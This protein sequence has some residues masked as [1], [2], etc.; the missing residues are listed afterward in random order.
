MELDKQA[1]ERFQKEE[2][3]KGVDEKESI[4]AIAGVT[5]DGD[6]TEDLFSEC[7]PTPNKTLCVQLNK[8]A[9]LEPI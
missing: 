9:D 8:D 3:A 4:Q 1:K 6:V 7:D 2:A 5:L